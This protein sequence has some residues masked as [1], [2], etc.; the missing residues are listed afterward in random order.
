MDD[1]HLAAQPA[2]TVYRPI[3]QEGF[4]GRLFVSTNRDPHT[5][6]PVVTRTIR[7]IDPDQPVERA[8]TLEEVRAELLSPERINA[9]VFSGFAGIALLIAVVGPARS[10]DRAPRGNTIVRPATRCAAI[11]SDRLV[12]HG[13]PER[14]TR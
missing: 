6:V 5:L 11:V 9:L 8:A 10:P 12:S 2:V 7:D 14:S 1:E 3:H 13:A 4:G